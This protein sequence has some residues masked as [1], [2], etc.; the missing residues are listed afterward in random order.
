MNELL[1]WLLLS[2][3]ID[4]T[5][6]ERKKNGTELHF[7]AGF[8]LWNKYLTR[9]LNIWA[10]ILQLY[11]PPCDPSSTLHHK[12]IYTHSVWPSRAAVSTLR[13]PHL[14]L[15]S[16]TSGWRWSLPASANTLRP[17]PLLNCTGRDRGA[18]EGK[19]AAWSGR[20]PI[21]ANSALIQFS[22][23]PRRWAIISAG[24]SVD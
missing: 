5:T 7:G 15:F 1:I 17:S 3:L 16:V 18:A 9:L 2:D 8:R 20:N 14:P 11:L 22:F 6:S 23:V 19:E 10:E 4:L 13:L 12:H 24:V 21:R